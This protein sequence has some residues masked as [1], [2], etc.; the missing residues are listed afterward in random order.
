MDRRDCDRKHTGSKRGKSSAN[1]GKLWKS[2]A[3]LKCPE[4]RGFSSQAEFRESSGNATRLRD[5]VGVTGSIPV[6]PTIFQPLSIS[7][8]V[9]SGSLNL[10]RVRPFRLRH[11]VS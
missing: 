2:S 3:V 8:R 4:E 7:L 9:L 11:S 6:A 10:N 5:I 1:G